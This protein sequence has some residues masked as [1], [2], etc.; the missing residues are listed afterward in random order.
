MHASISSVASPDRSVSSCVG[1]DA[2]GGSASRQ[3]A[4]TVRRTPQS[5]TGCAKPCRP[6]D[7]HLDYLV[8][9]AFMFPGVTQEVLAGRLADGAVRRAW[10]RWS[11]RELEWREVGASRMWRAIVA[12][13][14][15]VAVRL[16]RDDQ[17]AWVSLEFKGEAFTWLDSDGAA[18]LLA[19]F[20]LEVEGGLLQRYHAT[21]LDFAFD[22]G[23]VDPK[24]FFK[25]I[26]QDR[27]RSKAGRMAH[28]FLEDEHGHCTTYL[29]HR[30]V[31]QVR[32]YDRRGYNRF[33][34]ELRDEHAK[35]A[36]AALRG[37]PPSDWPSEAM[38]RLRGFFDVVDSSSPRRA[39]CG[40]L[41]MWA[42]FV[43]DAGVTRLQN[44]RRVSAESTPAGV[45]NGRVQRFRRTLAQLR[46]ALGDADFSAFLSAAA[47]RH[48]LTDSERY[49]AEALRDWIG[50][51]DGFEVRVV[52]DPSD[53]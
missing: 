2:E 40:L 49:E 12:G 43:G 28:N 35:Q 42:A 5:N 34:L 8:I 36:L 19:D 30:N 46:H 1:Q 45:F 20:D 21:R 17:A 6:V 9:T 31:R 32:C 24:R 23:G 13:P 53:F 26:R 41:P 22:H 4:D 50:F 3:L 38:S 27:I 10:S 11:D 48:V 39:R 37:L 14:P 16:P 33:E 44:R 25:W 7:F 47:G 51:L 15:G 52:D 18:A 29:G